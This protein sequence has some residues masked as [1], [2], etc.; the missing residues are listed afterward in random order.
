MTRRIAV[1][2]L[3]AGLSAFAQRD[4]DRDDHYRSWGREPLDRVKA[5]LNRTAANLRYLGPEEM[6]RFNRMRGQINEFQRKW[7]E[8]RFDKDVL[9]HI[10]EGLNHTVEHSR[11]RP[12]DR[13]IL[14]D[15]VRRLRELRERYDRERR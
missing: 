13:D 5:D 12:R 15:D 4:H 14:A 2:S 10:I 3:M 11:I 9:D 7:A 8:G 1:V 6:D